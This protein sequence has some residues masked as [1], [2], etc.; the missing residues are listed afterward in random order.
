MEGE[1]IHRLYPLLA[2]LADGR[3]HSGESLG[4]ALGVSRA[5]V[6]KK[7]RAIGALGLEVQAVNGKGYRLR[8][9]LELL[10]RDQILSV[11]DASTRALL[12]GLEILPEV[13]STNRYLMTR[14][15]ARIA[16]FAEYQQAG[17]GRRGRP[18][19]S[20]FA[21]NLYLSLSWRFD[22]P[23]TALSGLSLAVGV[24]IAE[25]LHDAGIGEGIQLKW[26][27]DI[28][29]RNRKLGGV[30][31]EMKGEAEGPCLAVIGVG[32]NLDMR[33]HDT[34]SIDQPWTDLHTITKRRPPRNR[35]AGLLLHH[36]LKGIVEYERHGLTPVHHRWNHL[37]CMAGK[38]VS[39]HLPSETLSGIAGGIDEKGALLLRTTN[40][41]RTI[42]SGEVT[43]RQRS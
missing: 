39:L 28:L 3:F 24:W 26:P 13:D 6:W 1:A 12:D 21:A 15:R 41:V 17:R 36:L 37:D 4:K 11:L 32:L 7:I 10:E 16:C 20:P 40:G 14:S 35:L 2:H 8:Q 27:N 43:L 19:L 22:G 42:H 38:P 29:H 9:P 23:A 18:W 25:A 34:G 5:A 30:L 33:G 31:V